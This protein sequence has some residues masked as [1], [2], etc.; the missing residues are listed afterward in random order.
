M[1]DALILHGKSARTQK[2]YVFAVAQLARYWRCSPEALSGDQVRA[3]LVYL[4]C[5]RGLSRSSVNQTGCAIR[6]LFLHVL[7]RPDEE[8]RIPLPRGPQRLP[9]ILSRQEIARLLS[10]APHL[11]ARCLLASIYALGLRVGEACALRI[12]QIDSAPDRMCVHVRHGKGGKDRYVPLSQDLL[13]LLRQYWREMH[14]KVWLFPGTAP[15][16]GPVGIERVQRWYQRARLN[17]GIRKI[18]GVHTL[19]H[20]YATHLLEAGVDLHS[21]SQWLGHRHVCTTSRYLH[22][23]HPG[24]PDGA[25]HAPLELLAGLGDTITP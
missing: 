10:C 23:A 4:L 3:Y 6:F 5:D 16:P 7:H 1:I 18:G 11:K 20:C 12:D 25:R 8:I 15:T 22:L 21:I 2:A 19:R 13:M 9:E 17:A 24:E 14:P